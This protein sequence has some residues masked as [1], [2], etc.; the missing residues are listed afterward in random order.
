LAISLVALSLRPAIVSVGSVLTAVIT[1]FHLTYTVAS[2]LTA[3]P[4]LLMG[5]LAL[6]TPM[7]ARRF[8]RDRLLMA[9][10]GLLCAATA[11]RSFSIGSFTLL[12][13]TMGI[14]AGIAVV[15]T[16]IPGFIKEQFSH[17]AASF[18]GVYALAC[19]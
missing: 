7:L 19:R 16:L 6:P 9:S 8:G 5:V 13:S 10:L 3:L 11:L 14:G 12:A 18:I 17:R 15:G 4:P 1:E 2:L